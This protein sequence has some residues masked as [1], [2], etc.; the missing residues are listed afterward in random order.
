[1][2]MYPNITILL[3]LGTYRTPDQYLWNSTEPAV[4]KVLSCGASS[5]QGLSS[6][7]SHL[8][9]EPNTSQFIIKG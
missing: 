5:H 2:T 6:S 7:V 3:V 4:G 1:M 9:L 8:K